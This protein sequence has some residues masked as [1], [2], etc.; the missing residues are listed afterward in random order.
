MYD[1]VDKREAPFYSQQRWNQLQQIREARRRN[2]IRN[3]HRVGDVVR[4]TNTYRNQYGIT[5]VVE[6]SSSRFVTIRN[7][8]TNQTYKRGW[9]N[10]ELVHRPS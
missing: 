6:S 3:P 7:Q 10:L 1:D 9:R 2:P 5:G 8:E 4:I